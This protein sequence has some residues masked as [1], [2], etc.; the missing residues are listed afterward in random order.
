MSEETKTCPYCAET[1]KAAAIK[2][3]YCHSDLS[4]PSGYETPE[5]QASPRQPPPLLFGGRDPIAISATTWTLTQ[6]AR[7]A[8]LRV[9]QEGEPGMAVRLVAPISN[10]G[11]NH[12]MFLDDRHLVGDHTVIAGL[13]HFRVDD[14]SWAYFQGCAID[15]CEDGFIFSSASGHGVD[16]SEPWEYASFGVPLLEWKGLGK[17]TRQASI[18]AYCPACA[19]DWMLDSAIANT[20][21]QEQGLGGKLQ[22]SGTRMEQF[23]AT[24]S[25]LSA[26]R[27]VAAGNESQRQAESLATLYALAACPRCR[28]TA[29]LLAKP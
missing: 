22:R 15:W 1:I 27:R 23:G 7:E 19:H 6:A 9:V 17:M 11:V 25:P 21:A 2:C 28:S 8:F 10:D 26:G 14:A 3:R 5:V 18:P 13:V 20:I 24:F 29:V 16:S 12:A 4:Q